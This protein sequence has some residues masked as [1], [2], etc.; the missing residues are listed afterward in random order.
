[1]EVTVPTQVQICAKMFQMHLPERLGQPWMQLQSNQSIV[2][3]LNR[4]QW[5]LGFVFLILYSAYIILLCAICKELAMMMY[6]DSAIIY[7]VNYSP[8][9]TLKAQLSLSKMID[10]P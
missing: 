6:A 9:C 3:P 10:Y 1:M 7:C 5:G 2:Q 8:T 4:Q